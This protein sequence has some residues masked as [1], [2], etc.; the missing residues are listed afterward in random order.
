VLR[1][2]KARRNIAA[3]WENIVGKTLD[4]LSGQEDRMREPD[5]WAEPVRRVQLKFQ[6]A[7]K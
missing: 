5:V 7:E 3:A 1:I 4:P 2:A 6:V